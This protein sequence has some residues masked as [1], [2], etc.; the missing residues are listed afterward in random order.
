MATTGPGGITWGWPEGFDG[1]GAN[2]DVNLQKLDAAIVS[3]EDPI[4]GLDS[5]YQSGDSPVFNGA[6][7]GEFSPVLRFKKL[8]GT[9][10]GSAGVTANVAHGLTLSKILS[11]DV[12]ATVGGAYA[13]LPRSQIIADC[14]YDVAITTTN[15]EVRTGSTGSDSILSA[16]FTVLITYEA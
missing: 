3:I 5:K 9:M 1:W 15:V 11:V 13:I 10:A 4:N 6:T 8:S 16:Q 12:L 7:I 2:N 14:F